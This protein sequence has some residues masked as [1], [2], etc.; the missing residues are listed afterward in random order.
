MAADRSGHA[1]RREELLHTAL[2]G[3]RRA[4]RVH[5]A[6]GTV[7]PPGAIAPQGA[8]LRGVR[9]VPPPGDR[10]AGARAARRALPDWVRSEEPPSR[11]G[12]ARGLT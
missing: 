9:R 4:L 5:D 8:G 1:Q 10:R 7:V 3:E 2:E 6:V 12:V 11:R